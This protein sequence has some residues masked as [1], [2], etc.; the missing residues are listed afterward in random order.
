MFATPGSYNTPMGV[1]RAIN[2][3]LEDTHRY[4]VVEM[5]AADVGSFGDCS[6]FAPESSLFAGTLAA[7]G[8]RRPAATPMP[9]M[10]WV[11]NRRRSVLR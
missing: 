6:A 7:C 2:E 3:N 10:I 11:A 8:A 5:G 9:L 1:V 4:V